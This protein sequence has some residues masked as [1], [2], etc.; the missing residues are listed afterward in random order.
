MSDGGSDMPPEH[1]ERFLASVRKFYDAGFRL[2]DPDDERVP[3]LPY[4]NEDLRALVGTRLP[5]TRGELT[6]LVRQGE[7]MLNAR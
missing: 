7:R 3:I 5:Y 2:V 1:A 4:T 6:A